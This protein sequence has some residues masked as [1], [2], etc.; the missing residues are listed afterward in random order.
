MLDLFLGKNRTRYLVFFVG[1]ASCAPI[2]ML[3]YREMTAGQTGCPAEE[4]EISEG[5]RVLWVGS[6]LSW[7]ASC[8][9]K[10]YVCSHSGT[11]TACSEDKAVEPSEASFQSAEA[12]RRMSKRIQ[13]SESNVWSR[14]GISAG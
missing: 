14:N 6:S 1:L 5:K 10:E 13:N 12:A 7:R 9:G 2:T 11:T 8:G 3:Q 4:I